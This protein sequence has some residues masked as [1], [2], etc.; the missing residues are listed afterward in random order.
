MTAQITRGRHDRGSP[1]AAPQPPAPSRHR[2]TKIDLKFSPYIF[3]SPFFIIFAIFGAFP[4]AYTLWVSLRKWDLLGG[5]GGFVGLDNYSAILKDS[6]FWN[7]VYNTFGIFLLATIPQILLALV[8]AYWLN[9]K[10]R[11]RTA[12]RMGVLVPNVTSVAAVAIVFSQLFG[13]DFGL[14]NWLIGFVGI[15]PIDWPAGRYSAW[16][17]VATM[18]DWR[19][20]GYHALILLAAMQAIPK[21]LYESASIDGASALRQ[22][23]QITVPLLRPTLLFSVI[24]ATIGGL[25]L[26]TEPLLFNGSNN[27]IL[28]GS[29]RQSQT[30]AMYLYE[31]GFTRFNF[32]Y[33]A[34]IA[35]LLFLLIIIVSLANLVL[36]RRLA[37]GSK[38]AE[39]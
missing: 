28:G 26:F 36:V 13:R 30:V 38:G 22:F 15:D 10:L 39:Q 7:A 24:I 31:Q 11:A 12:F 25:Q 21:D 37:G 5:D 17:A 27:A 9:K 29:L 3:I 23:W 35:W 20:T 2:L 14:I 1:D 18:V 6:W 33:G 16:F 32:G 8:T 4:L 34:A 19:W